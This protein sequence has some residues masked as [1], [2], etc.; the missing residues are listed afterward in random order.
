MARDYR[1]LQSL[2]REPFSMEDRE[3]TNQVLKNFFEIQGKGDL[4]YK[5]LVLLD[6]EKKV[7][8]AYSP[9]L[10]TTASTMVGSSYAGIAFEGKEKSSHTV[11][12]LYRPDKGHPMGSKGIE[13]AIPIRIGEEMLGW[14][15]FQMDMAY[16]N[17][18]VE[19]DEEA[20]K[21]F[22]FEDS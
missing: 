4:P 5:G 2:L 14:I 12:V 17:K 22:R 11:L 3:K 8:D 19:I 15:V 18:R 20:M 1:L 21:Q 6:K 13:L 16:L 9:S 7:F 10:P